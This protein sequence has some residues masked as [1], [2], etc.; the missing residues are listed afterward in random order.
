MAHV[1]PW[2]QAYLFD[3]RLRR[4]FQKSERIF[5]NYVRQGMVVMDVGCG[6][7]FHSI[8]LARMVGPGG[9][10]VAVDV[11]QKMLDVLMRRAAKQG[12]SE[13]IRTRRCDPDAICTGH[14]YDFIN[15]F[16]MVHE[17]SNVDT[18]LKQA[19]LLL[20]TGGHLFIA[21]PRLHVS[22]ASFEKTVAG[23]QEMNLT[24]RAR[25]CV[26]FSRAAVF[27]KD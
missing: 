26:R 2:W 22:A 1:C 9:M 21:E 25:P 4:L 14:T 16:W 3:N 8:A 7:G 24:L 6:M 23:A 18:F 27:I 5:G 10:V 12:V 20:K 19:R 15:A 17:V 13:R 11:Q